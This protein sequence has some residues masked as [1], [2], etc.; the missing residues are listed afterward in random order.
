MR[1]GQNK[2]MRGRNRR[3]PNPLTRSY[4][5]NGPDVKVRGTAQHIAEKYTQLARDAHASG[6]PVMA[7]SYLQHAEH[8]Y[9]LIA[10]AMQAQQAQQSGNGDERYDEDEDFDPASDRF[11]FRPVQQ[12]QPQQ[13]G[14]FQPYAGESGEAG[15]GEEVESRPQQQG[16]QP[17]F[18]QDRP[19]HQDRRNGRGQE[20]Q[21]FERPAHDR[22]ASER[23]AFDSNRPRRPQADPG[24]G[25]QPV[26]PAFLTAPAR[27]APAEAEDAGEPMS[28]GVVVGGRSPFRPRRRRR[29]RGAREGGDEAPLAVE[30][31][32]D[33]G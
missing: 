4:E 21:P 27:P 3:G 23:P 19:R 6:D 11:T 14:Q 26:L 7:E 17:R 8:Y 12:H 15:E 31:A 29:G 1:P 32:S 9:R 10:A 30:G 5:S 25:E 22:P 20:R 33:E 28:G 2:R 18:G 13:V 16:G 24:A